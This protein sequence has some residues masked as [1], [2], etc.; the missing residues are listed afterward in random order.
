MNHSP[1]RLTLEQCCSRY[2]RLTS[3]LKEV[4]CLST[5]EAGCCIRDYRDG[6]PYS[7]EAVSHAGLSPSDWVRHAVAARQCRKLIWPEGYR[8]ILTAHHTRRTP[9]SANFTQEAS[10]A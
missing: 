7:C 1:R 2:P 5:V 10:H 8:H 9:T 4:A 3:L 6:L